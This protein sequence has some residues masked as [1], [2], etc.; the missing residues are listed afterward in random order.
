MILLGIRG[1][2]LTRRLNM[3]AKTIAA[4][5]VVLLASIFLFLAIQSDAQADSS[6]SSDEWTFNQM[7]EKEID[8]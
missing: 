3:H 8:W 4:R 5:W 6:P 2:G 7:L 1:M